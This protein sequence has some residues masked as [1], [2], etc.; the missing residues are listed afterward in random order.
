MGAMTRDRI[1]RDAQQRARPNTTLSKRTAG[2][3]GIFHRVQSYPCERVGDRIKRLS[4]APL[5]QERSGRY[6]SLLR[7]TASSAPSPKGTILNRGGL[8]HD[9]PLGTE[10]E[11]PWELVREAV[12]RLSG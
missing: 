3:A 6:V 1:L 2:N 4:S 7:V 11:P 9:P 5:G 10:N 12:P 8:S